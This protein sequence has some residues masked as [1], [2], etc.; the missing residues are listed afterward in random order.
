MFKLQ[1]DCRRLRRQL[2]REGR[3]QLDNLRRG[4]CRPLYERTTKKV[5]AWS[6]KEDGP[7]NNIRITQSI[8]PSPCFLGIPTSGRVTPK[9]WEMRPARASVWRKE[10]KGVEGE[11]LNLMMEES[12]YILGL[13]AGALGWEESA[14]FIAESM[15]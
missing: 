14:S 2:R 13:A 4:L 9:N 12:M 10:W 6:K 11:D 5:S 7:R 15:C 3:G 8:S 1:L